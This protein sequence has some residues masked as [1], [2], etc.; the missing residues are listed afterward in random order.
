MKTKKVPIAEIT[1]PTTRVTAVYDDELRELLKGTMAKMG[2]ITPVVVVQTTE[3]FRLVDGLHRLQEA[4]AAKLETID[5]V[6]YEG[7]EKDTLLTNLVLNRTRGK[8][9]ASEMVKVIAAL[10]TEY[11]MDSEAIAERTG[12]KRDYI[13]Q[14]ML[15]S[16]ASPSVLEL[17]DQEIIGVGAAFQIQRLPA[18]EQQDELCARTQIWRY[19]VAEL[20]ALV[21]DTL[22]MMKHIP[23][24][25]PPPP[26]PTVIKYHC[27]G[28]GREMQP[29]DIKA[30]GLCPDCFGVIWQ[31]RQKVKLEAEAAAAAADEKSSPEAQEK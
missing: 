13:E 29:R 3:G 28:C 17:L 6:V 8:T 7:E 4:Q 10:A 27:E 2:M 15:I 5:A 12:L 1:I 26:P 30:I 31:H 11:E 24:G 9:R 20:K 16:Q 22:E 18:K 23:Q 25:A 14:L 21:D 19:S